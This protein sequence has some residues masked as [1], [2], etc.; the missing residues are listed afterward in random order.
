MRMRTCYCLGKEQDQL[1]N[2]T[3][4][5][6]VYVLEE[7]VLLLSLHWLKQIACPSQKPVGSYK[8]VPHINENNSSGQYRWGQDLYLLKTWTRIKVDPGKHLAYAL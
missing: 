3:K 7:T 1:S 5:L 8:K 4:V 6:I 2:H